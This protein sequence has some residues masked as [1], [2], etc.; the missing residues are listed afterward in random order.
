[1]R[2]SGTDHGGG[3]YGDFPA[4]L[5]RSITWLGQSLT[6]HPSPRRAAPLRQEAVIGVGWGTMWS[7]PGHAIV[8]FRSKEVE[9]HDRGHEC[10]EIK[11][12]GRDKER[13]DKER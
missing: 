2:V 9:R 10:H 12:W 7:G 1:M 5:A 8:Q 13:R 4:C 3:P 11:Q 6:L